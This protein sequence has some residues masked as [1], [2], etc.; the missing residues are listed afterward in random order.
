MNYQFTRRLSGRAIADYRSVLPNPSRV[1]LVGDRQLVTD[2]LLT[3]FVQ[4]GTA[5]YVG[6]TAGFDDLVASDTGARFG[7]PTNPKARQ[8]FVKASY[9]FRL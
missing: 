1:A 2:L 4:P 7:P 3:Y 9:L 8:F 5:I 6:Y